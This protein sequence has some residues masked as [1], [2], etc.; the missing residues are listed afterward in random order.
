MKL[1][2][3]YPTVCC[4]VTA[5]VY[6]ACLLALVCLFVCLFAC[7]VILQFNTIY[8]RPIKIKSRCNAMQCRCTVLYYGWFFQSTV[9]WYDT[10]VAA[11]SKNWCTYCTT[12]IKK[13]CCRYLLFVD[14]PLACAVVALSIDRSIDRRGTC[15]VQVQYDTVL[16]TDIILTRIVL[17]THKTAVQVLY[18]RSTVLYC[19]ILYY[20]TIL[21]ALFT[22][23]TD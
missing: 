12:V 1:N 16:I 21:C 9:L 7:L 2:E 14:C 10:D 13:R 4:N 17:R 22:M 19:T 11:K 23:L 3:T 6:I 18:Y 20:C 15:T 5:T 8:Q